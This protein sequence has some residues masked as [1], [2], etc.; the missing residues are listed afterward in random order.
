MKIYNNSIIYF[1]VKC[2]EIALQVTKV[3]LGSK[4]LWVKN[5]FSPTHALQVPNYRSKIEAT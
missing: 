3:Q 5:S 1:V 4:C 2:S